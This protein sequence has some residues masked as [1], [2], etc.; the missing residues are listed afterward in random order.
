LGI[1]GG[2]D[3]VKVSGNPDDIEWTSEDK[4]VKP[5]KRKKI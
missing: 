5:I 1:D 4:E 3:Y 2:N